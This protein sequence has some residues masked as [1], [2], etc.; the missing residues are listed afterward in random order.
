MLF[1]EKNFKDLSKIFYA[2]EPCVSILIPTHRAGHAQEDRIR[3]KNALAEA[4]EKL[5]QAHIVFNNEGMSE[6]EVKGFLMP[7]HDLLE[8]D[9]FWLHQSD[10]LAVFIGNNLFE[11]YEVPIN[12]EPRVY[13]HHHYYLYPLL[14]L[15]DKNDRFFLLALSQ[16]EVRFFEGHQYT[17]T[18]VKIN[19]LVPANFTAAMAMED[20]E[21]SLQMHGSGDA[22]IHHGQG[23]HKDQKDWQIEQFCRMVDDGLMEMLHDENA[24]MIVAGVDELVAVYKNISNYKDMV[25]AHVGGNPENDDPV[26]L[27]E[28]AWAKMQPFFQEKIKAQKELFD[29]ALAKN[30][31]SA[32]LL[33]IVPAA[34]NGKVETLFLAEGMPV[35][36]GYHAEQDNTVKIHEKRAPQSMC[37]INLAAVKTYEQGG[38]VR[39]MDQI[40]L[41]AS[42]AQANAI[43]R[44]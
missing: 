29:G 13:I 40:Q 15:L 44:Y 8:K 9:D 22:A 21:K 39:I 25:A 6:K 16:G 11:H 17:I 7:A 42:T 34:V 31:A 19:D 35:I 1:N 32:S 5:R 33:D 24:P 43:F 38:T 41:P 20:P 27:H 28:K 3:F 12:F 10:G 26:L 2:S 18:P 37:L 14:P 30:K 4:S 36:W 23:I